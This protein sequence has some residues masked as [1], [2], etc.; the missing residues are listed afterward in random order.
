MNL[1]L[2]QLGDSA[3]PVGG[4]SH[5][6]GL[7]AAIDRGLV[8]DPSGLEAWARAWLEHSLGPGEGVVVAAVCREPALAVAANELVR[9]SLTP[10]SLRQAS[11]DMGTQLLALASAWPWAERGIAALRYAGNES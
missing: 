8:R 4:Y 3:L 9:A 5:S 6:W 10:P 1:A 11:R 7:E 2:L